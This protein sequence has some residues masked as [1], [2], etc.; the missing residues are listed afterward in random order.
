MLVASLIM[1]NFS[2]RVS[3]NDRYSVKYGLK[4]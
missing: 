2:D 1:A 3:S 4:R